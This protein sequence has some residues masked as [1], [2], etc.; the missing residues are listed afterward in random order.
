MGRTFQKAPVGCHIFIGLSHNAKSW[1]PYYY[2][3][4]PAAAVPLCDFI[5]KV[6]VWL[7]GLCLIYRLSVL[8]ELELQ[9][10]LQ[11]Q[12]L[13]CSLNS[14]HHLRFAHNPII[15]GCLRCFNQPVIETASMAAGY[16]LIALEH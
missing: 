5:V 7:H 16:I 6:F 10:P 1:E 3:S 11:L 12:T 15:L 2:Y 9:W 8:H 13:C 4:R 14:G